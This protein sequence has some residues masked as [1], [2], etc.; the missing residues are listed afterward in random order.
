MPKELDSET[1]PRLEVENDEL[2]EQ[3]TGEE[4]EEAVESQGKEAEEDCKDCNNEFIQFVK[5]Q[6]GEDLSNYE[7]DVE[8]I[9][10]LINAR[11]AVGRK[12]SDAKLA[13]AI[14]ERYGSNFLEK[15]LDGRVELP[16]SGTMPQQQA[17]PAQERDNQ[18]D[19][20]E[21]DPAWLTMVVRDENGQLTAAPGAPKD[22]PEKLMRFVRHR[23]EVMNEFAK[24]PDRFIDSIIGEKIRHAIQEHVNRSLS[25]I[26]NAA[27]EHQTVSQWAS[28][29]RELL[30]EGGDVDGELTEVGKK[31][32]D[33]ADRLMADGVKSHAKALQRAWEMI[34]ESM[35]LQRKP[36][37]KP[38]VAA[39]H[40]P[41]KTTKT[42]TIEDLIDQG[43]GLAAAY[44]VVSGKK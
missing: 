18:R 34:G 4:D 7:N 44:R 16:A 15:L 25:E 33:L 10:G 17:T 26:G 42:P 29:N 8:A 9:K 5:E 28:A 39:M 3:E 38:N 14:R 31:I 32:V 37:R 1:T 30:F 27:V 40:V 24:N 2:E 13:R 21:F 41:N 11:R 22:I 12:D 35:K 20:V 6:F 43:Y 23:E 36:I 19:E